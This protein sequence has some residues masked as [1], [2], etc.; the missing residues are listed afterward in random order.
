MLPAFTGYNQRVYFH[1]ELWRSNCHSTDQSVKVYY[2]NSRCISSAWSED[3]LARLQKEWQSIGA[4]QTKLRGRAERHRKES[5]E[6]ER[7]GGRD[8]RSWT[9]GHTDQ[10]EQAAR[11]SDSDRI[12]EHKTGSGACQAGQEVDSCENAVTQDG[13]HLGCQCVQ[14]IAGGCQMN[15]RIMEEVGCHQSGQAPSCTVV[16]AGSSDGLPHLSKGLRS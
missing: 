9:L 15:E 6:R 14:R 11:C 2:C 16:S 8:R 12:R 1:T 10:A 4:G 5:G 7:E 3:A 13:L